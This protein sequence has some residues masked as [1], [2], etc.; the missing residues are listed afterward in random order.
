[1]QKQ[2]K[3]VGLVSSHKPYKACWLKEPPSVKEI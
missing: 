2:M 3:F 1:M